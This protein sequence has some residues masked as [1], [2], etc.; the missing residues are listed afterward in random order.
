MRCAGALWAACAAHRSAPPATNEARRFSCLCTRPAGMF[1]LNN[2]AVYVPSPVSAWLA[3]LE[4]L[5]DQQSA[6]AYLAAG[7][8]CCSRT[9]R[10]AGGRAQPW[11][12][13]HLIY[14]EAADGRVGG[15]A[16]PLF[17]H[18]FCHSTHPAP[19]S[20]SLPPTQAPSWT[21]CPRSCR[22]ARATPFTRCTGGAGDGGE[23]AKRGG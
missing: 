23:G 9:Q 19:L 5:P 11:A 20:T 3:A 14:A 4:A 10:G 2:L 21:P 7:A 15:P 1:E 13:A 12:H 8:G 16:A 17:R 18:D 6:A 22:A